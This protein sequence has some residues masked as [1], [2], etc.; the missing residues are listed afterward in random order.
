MNSIPVLAAPCVPKP[1]LTPMGNRKSKDPVRASS[2]GSRL[3]ESG[4]TLLRLEE[5]LNDCVRSPTEGFK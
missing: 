5:L 4:R 2:A 3:P 1:H